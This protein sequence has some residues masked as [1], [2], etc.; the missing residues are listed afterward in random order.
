MA[1][2]QEKSESAVIRDALQEYITNNKKKAN[3][4]TENNPLS[5]IIGLGQSGKNDI[6]ENHDDYLYRRSDRKGSERNAKCKPGQDE[7]C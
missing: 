1:Y 4:R 3:Q 6:S 2:I 7:T 5:N